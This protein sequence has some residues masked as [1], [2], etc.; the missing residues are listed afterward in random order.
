M[1]RIDF[2]IA[3]LGPCCEGNASHILFGISIAAPIRLAELVYCVSSFF[4]C[5]FQCGGVGMGFQIALFCICAYYGW[6]Y[7]A[8]DYPTETIDID[9]WDLSIIIIDG[10]AGKNLCA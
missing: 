6:T 4:N 7:H 1:V 5:F 10:F 2:E 3:G 8:L 9:H